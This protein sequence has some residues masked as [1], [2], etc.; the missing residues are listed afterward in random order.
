[1]NNKKIVTALA[2]NNEVI[3]AMINERKY[4]P[5]YYSIIEHMYFSNLK[6]I[7]ILEK[8]P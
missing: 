6:L 7:K 1:M 2:K 5:L 8:K 3:E 4:N